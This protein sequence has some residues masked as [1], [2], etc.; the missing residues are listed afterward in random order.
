MVM[1]PPKSDHSGRPYT[2]AK[3]YVDA[4]N[5]C[6]DF[7]DCAL[8]D[9]WHN[10]QASPETNYES[11]FYDSSHPNYYGMRRIGSLLANRIKALYTGLVK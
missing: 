11:F 4:I 10:M 5:T 2:K 7:W 9:L 6:I 1:N 3:Q 8:V